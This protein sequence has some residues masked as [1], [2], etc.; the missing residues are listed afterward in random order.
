[1]KKISGII[2]AD[3]RITTVDLRSG[4]A[5][6]PGMPSFGRR[7]GSSPLQRPEFHTTQQAMDKFRNQL[8]LDSVRDH[9]AAIVS[10]MANQFFVREGHEENAPRPRLEPEQMK[11]N[12]V[13]DI[14]RGETPE[15]VSP[16]IR[17]SRTDLSGSLNNTVQTDSKDPGD[18][19]VSGQHLDV[20]A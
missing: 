17:N 14:E 1:M 12:E 18:Q 7:I 10:K 16:E 4:G 3:K 9:Q 13:H 15:I 2:P 6:R 8:H 5:M 19:L 11:M 20:H